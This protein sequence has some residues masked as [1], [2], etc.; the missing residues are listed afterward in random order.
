M[1]S[2]NRRVLYP[3]DEVIV[4]PCIGSDTHRTGRPSAAT[5]STIAG[6]ASRILPAPIRVMNV[7]RP[8]VPSGL[9][10]SMRRTASSGEVVGPSFTPIGLCTREKKSTCA[11]VRSRVRSPIHRKC[12]EQVYGRP[13]RESIRVRGRS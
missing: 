6:S 12:A 13:V 11:P 8:G 4:F 5:R 9:S 10:A 7:S 2:A 3:F 1:T